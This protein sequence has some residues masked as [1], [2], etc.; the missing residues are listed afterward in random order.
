MR[1][2]PLESQQEHMVSKGKMTSL[3]CQPMLGWQ[4]AWNE[5]QL[6]GFE[7]AIVGTHC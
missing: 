2:L 7:I 3:L 1:D 5:P 6:A 4:R